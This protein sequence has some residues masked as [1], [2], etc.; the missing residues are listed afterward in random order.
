MFEKLKRGLLFL[1][2]GELG[3]LIILTFLGGIM[4]LLFA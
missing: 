1:L 3:L 4:Y 2:K